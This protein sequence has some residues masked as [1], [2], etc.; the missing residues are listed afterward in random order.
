MPTLTIAKPRCFRLQSA[1]DFDTGVVPGSGRAA[2]AATHELVLT[3][4]L[5]R[6]FEAVAARLGE[7]RTSLTVD[8]SGT[9]DLV[10]VQNQ[11]E[12]MLGLEGDGEAWARLGKESPVVGKLQA[13]FPGFFTAT[14][15]SPYDAAVWAILAARVQM[16]A[17]AAV[18]I[19]MA[20][21]HGTAVSL[22]DS[23]YHVFPAPAVLSEIDGFPGVSG[24]KME[25]LRGIGRAALDG[26]LDAATLRGMPEDV[27]LH[28]LQ[29]LRGIGP[30]AAG[31]IYFR[32]A[33]PM[34]AL[35]TVEPRV[36]H[37]LA[38]VLGVAPIS[39]NDFVRHAESWRP[40]RMWVSV[41][42][43]R[44]L[45]RT[46]EWRSP[47]L[48]RERAAAGRKLASAVAVVR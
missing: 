36:L 32:G 21:A 46:V 25:R 37:G 42:L 7:N 35:P 4:R 18:K 19:A 11:L 10:A 16:R 14:K 45:A 26:K 31:H 8:V 5:D 27:A 6:T 22:G 9:R 34:D 24:E 23:V 29:K 2:A 30:W 44:H 38:H 39:P 40:F 48:A 17:A 41:L 28:E 3:F 47:S 13:E 43:S 20:R 12:R 15:P 1:L 33:A